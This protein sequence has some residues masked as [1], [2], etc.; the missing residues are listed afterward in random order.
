MFKDYFN[1][2]YET[3]QDANFANKLFTLVLKE[4][5]GRFPYEGWRVLCAALEEPRKLNISASIFKELCEILSFIEK[6]LIVNWHYSQNSS[7]WELQLGKS[8]FIVDKELELS[9]IKESQ[10]LFK[11]LND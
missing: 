6:W 11:I 9:E 5:Y 8:Q 10:L 4:A 1:N 2:S 3:E 7:F